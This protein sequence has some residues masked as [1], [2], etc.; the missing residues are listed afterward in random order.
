VIRPLIVF[1]NLI[2]YMP[3]KK[4]GQRK[5]AEKQKERQKVIQKGRLNAVEIHDH[6][7]NSEM[8]C[9]SCGK[10]QKNR[11]FCYF[12]GSV[13]KN[14]Q[15]CNCG[16]TKCLPGSSDCVIKHPGINAT[17]LAMVGAICDYCEAWI[18]HSKRCLQTHACS[19]PLKTL[20]KPAECIE[21]DRSVWEHGGKMYT[22]ITC[23]LWL[24][25]DDFFEHQASC[26]QLE[27]ENFKCV[28]CNKFGTLTCLRCKISFCDDHFGSFMGKVSNLDAPCKKCGYGLRETK[29][30]SIS[31]KTHEYGRQE[32]GDYDYEDEQDENEYTE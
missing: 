19:C 3:I 7:S 2:L 1:K 30:L 16:R 10:V 13:Q 11:S 26:Q 5:K 31:T 29:N 9:K 28:S 25:S 17:G 20:E 8:D 32:Y 23:E 14:P 12:C 4:S 18:C 24:C 22:C 27:G 21:C 6:P 15:C